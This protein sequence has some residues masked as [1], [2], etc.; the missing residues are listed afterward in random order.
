LLWQVMSPRLRSRVWALGVLMAL[1]IGLY[2]SG[3][4]GGFAVGAGALLLSFAIMPAYRRILPTLLLMLGGVA[5][6]A[7]VLKPGLGH[8][9]L[10]AV[11]LAGNT[12]SAKGSDTVRSEVAHQGWMDFQ[13]SPID[14]VGMQ[15]AEQAHNVYLQ[16]L[17]SGG[18][19]LFIC[20]IVFVLSGLAKSFNRISW[21]PLAYPFFVAALSGALLA[22]VENAL[23]DRLAY[24]PLAL[25]AAMPLGEVSDPD[26]DVPT[27]VP[28]RDERVFAYP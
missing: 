2:A 5:A 22:A 24:V 4:R 3:S 9:L 11:R 17:A 1:L 15:V 16:A 27:T 19:M 14:G 8:K 13:H 10:Q 7:F 26:N 21:D 12:G 25:I 20:Y 18:L 6:L 28:E 23:V